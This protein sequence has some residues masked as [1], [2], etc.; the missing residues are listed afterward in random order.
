MWHHSSG[1]RSSSRCSQQE[2]V[3]P[4]SWSAEGPAELRSRT[5]C[6]GGGCGNRAM[7]NYTENYMLSWPVQSCWQLGIWMVILI[8]EMLK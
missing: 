2:P 6:F 3:L 4:S 1:A 8:M 7:M 5:G